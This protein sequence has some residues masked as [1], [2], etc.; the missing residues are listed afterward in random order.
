MGQGRRHSSKAD[1]NRG[2]RTITG[3]YGKRC[4]PIVRFVAST[5]VVAAVSVSSTGTAYAYKIDTDPDWK[6]NLDNSVMYTAGWRAQSINPYIANNP[7]Y[8]QGDTRFA[9]GD[10]V[11]NRI[12]DLIEFQGIYQDKFGFR[13]TGS[14]WKDWA[15]HDNISG[16]PA[17]LALGLNDSPNGMS[18]YTKRFQY[19]GGEL[20]DAFVFGSKKIGDIDWHAKVG[21]LTQ[22]WGNA[23]YFGF[24]NIAYGQS[25]VDQIKGF[26]QPGSELKELFLPRKQILLSA[27][28]SPEL[29][30]AAQY[31]FEFGANRYP[32]SGT[33]FSAAD[34]LYKGPTSVP[35]LAGL[36]GGPVTAGNEN[37]PK[38]NNGNFGVK[39]AWSPEW[40]QGDL[41]FYYRV[42]DDPHPWALLDINTN[43]TGGDV[44]LDYAQKIKLYGLSYERTFGTVS[45]GFEASYRQNTGLNSALG[46]FQPGVA[47]HGATGD[48]VNLIA[49]AFIQ[50]GHTPLYDTGLL[51]A[52]LSHTHLVSVTGNQSMYNGVGY[53]GCGGGTK[54]T[55]C[56]T[57]DATALWVSFEPQWLQVFPRVDISMPTSYAW[58]VKGTPAY[59]AGA[60][61]AQGTGLYNIGVKALFDG[62][63]SI[64]LSYNGIN[65]RSRDIGNGP[66]G[67]MYATGSGAYALKDRDWIS[68][69]LKTSF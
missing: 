55:G 31:F 57:K 59:G 19:Q 43:S 1:K 51:I 54:W 11:T 30:V 26:S 40:A 37:K 18:S 34:F 68:L 28:I 10:M 33:Y 3:T 12:Q 17:L 23:F 25:G 46:T 20:L 5:A 39:A 22:F 63:T 50:L 65:W 16:N 62:K 24:S 13:V 69:T 36:A 53:A 6:L 27:D 61:Y 67:P 52:E 38:N 56:S 41:G 35:A 60:F 66:A 42:L 7:F 58:G 49:N 44:H 32:E 15:Y 21:R 47:S 14:A 64:A 4:F 2:V 9:K 8:H 48:I 45:T 29:S